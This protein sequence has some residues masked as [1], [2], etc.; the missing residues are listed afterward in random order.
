M[1]YI[2]EEPLDEFVT[3]YDE[4]TGGTIYIANRKH[5]AFPGWL[6]TYVGDSFARIDVSL[7][8]PFQKNK[9]NAFTHDTFVD[10]RHLSKFCTML[11][12]Y[13]CVIHLLARVSESRSPLCEQQKSKSVRSPCFF[14][15]A[16]TLK[17]PRCKM[18]R[19]CLS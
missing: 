17:R 10:R 14:Y 1:S 13:A 8:A 19:S 2:V 3:V 16:R 18:V 12:D 9:S 5:L 6:A 15:S 11:I 7:D 4:V